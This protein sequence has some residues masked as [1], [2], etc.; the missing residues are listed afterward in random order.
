MANPTLLT[1][2]LAQNG[3]KNII[4]A[5]ASAS[6]GVFS[7]EKGWQ[8]INSLPVQQGGIAP[9]RL[10]FNGA[11]N[12][13]SKILFYAQKGWRFEYDETQDYYAGCVVKD[14]D[15]YMYEAL[16]DI[17][18][19][20]THPKDDITNWQK[21]DLSQ[22]LPLAGGGALTGTSLTWNGNDLG[23]SAIV[24]SIITGDS[25]GYRR[26]ADGY[27]IQWGMITDGTYP[28]NKTVTYPISFTTRMYGVFFINGSYTS[29][30]NPT[31]CLKAES[32]T[33]FTV[34]MSQN[35]NNYVRWVAFGK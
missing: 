4:P 6:S 35:F 30:F 24:S 3:D 22:Y 14:T 10:D 20:S 32:L 1:I 21:H 23:G 17:P 33:G 13:I 16:N 34:Y 12:L 7:Q 18:A 27:T 26:T 2:P 15:G 31:Y 29:T 19:S 9:D 25:T 28:G 5:T 11:F 8:N